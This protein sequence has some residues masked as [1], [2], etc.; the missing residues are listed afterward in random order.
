MKNISL[1][2]LFIA[3]GF[4]SCDKNDDNNNANNCDLETLIS[5][6]Q[7][8]NAPADP[9]TINRL[10]IE[11]NCLKIN[12]SSGGCSGS[13]WK[14]KL[15]DSEA[16]LK[17]NPP[18]RNLRLSLKDEELCEAWITKEL[19]FDLSKLQLDGDKVILNITNAGESI[20]YK[21]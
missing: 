19:S 4:W 18:Q 12:F 13:S 8:S 1:A 7:Y 3:I 16:I 5:S 2:F 21:Y 20:L 6:D 14:I 11:D 10:E 17:S 15:I 9:L